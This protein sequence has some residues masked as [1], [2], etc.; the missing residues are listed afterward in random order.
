MDQAIEVEVDL[1]STVNLAM[2]QN[3]VPILR[4]LRLRNGLPTALEGLAITIETE[5]Q[6]ARPWATRLDKLEAG[7]TRVLSPV[8]L[9]L[10]PSSLWR[11]SER[12]VG[13]VLVKV[14]K[15]EE[16]LACNSFPIEVLA[17]DE[18]PGLRVLPE[19]LAAF[20]LPNHPAVETVLSRASALLRE[21]T[22]D[23]SLSGYQSKE[24]E[25]A[26]Y[27]GAAI[28]GALQQAG[29]SYSNPPAS[30]EQCGQKIRL[31]DRI[32]ENHL[33]SCLDLSTFYAAC[34][35]QAGLLIRHDIS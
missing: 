34:L 11:V 20:V 31:P 5:P 22:G 10:L 1:N 17:H 2:Q 30:F 35:E 3:E 13:A 16:V 28:F 26:L 7:E 9:Y 25:R 15:G 18:W 27:M 24:R 29:I 32:L 8:D 23:G 21:W 12:L 33:G 19:I 4:S 14:T 6:F